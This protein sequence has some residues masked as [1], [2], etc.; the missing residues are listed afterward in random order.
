MPAFG[1]GR[2]VNRIV[3][4]PDG[5]SREDPDARRHPAPFSRAAHI[6]PVPSELSGGTLGQMTSPQPLETG[7]A[8]SGEVPSG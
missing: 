5:A 2:R 8:Y 4:Q 1:A 6:G 7:A 3:R